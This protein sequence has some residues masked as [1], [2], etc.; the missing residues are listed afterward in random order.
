MRTTETLVVTAVVVAI[1]ALGV[2]TIVSSA[3]KAGAES[4]IVSIDELHRNVPKNLPVLEIT[5]PF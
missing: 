5:D 3:P 1:I 2:K 4:N